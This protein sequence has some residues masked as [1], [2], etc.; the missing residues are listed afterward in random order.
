M[1]VK[2]KGKTLLFIT[3]KFL[4]VKLGFIIPAYLDLSESLLFLRPTY[5]P[6]WRMSTS[7]SRYSSFCIVFHLRSPGTGHRMPN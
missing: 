4:F 3:I 7:A 6:L 5:P 2:S 1:M